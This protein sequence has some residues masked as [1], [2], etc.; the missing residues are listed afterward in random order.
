MANRASKTLASSIM[1]RRHFLRTSRESLLRHSAKSLTGFDGKSGTKGQSK[2]RV[3]SLL[4]GKASNLWLAMESSKQLAMSR[5]CFLTGA[6]GKE[7]LWEMGERASLF[8]PLK[9]T[10][11]FWQRHYAPRNS[12]KRC[13]DH[14]ER[15]TSCTSTNV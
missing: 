13:P 6:S 11:F 3:D 15:E 8:S 7:V 12:T 2:L 10:G 9:R 5:L 14:R 1:A 4:F